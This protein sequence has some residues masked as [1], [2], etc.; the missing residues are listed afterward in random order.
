MSAFALYVSPFFSA[1]SAVRDL[2]TYNMRTN[3]TRMWDDLPLLHSTVH[4]ESPMKGSTAFE[5][6]CATAVHGTVRDTPRTSKHQPHKSHVTM[7]ATYNEGA[8]RHLA[9]NIANGKRIHFLNPTTGQDAATL[10]AVVEH[11]EMGH[12]S[13][14]TFVRAFVATTANMWV[15]SVASKQFSALALDPLVLDPQYLTEFA[16][17]GPSAKTNKLGRVRT[18]LPAR[19]RTASDS[20]S[21]GDSDFGLAKRNEGTDINLRCTHNSGKMFAE[22][23]STVLS[24]LEQHKRQQKHKSRQSNFNN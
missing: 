12:A 6:N 3:R 15:E 23:A 10:N 11:F 1:A 20:S 18:V 8:A 14:T 16:L 13:P 22:T 17:D 9:L 2:D 5:N 4:I 24:M 21:N 19:S 7:V